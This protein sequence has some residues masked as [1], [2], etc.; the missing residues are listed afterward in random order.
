[1]RHI[2]NAILSKSLDWVRVW[3]EPTFIWRMSVKDALPLR[4]PAEGP[5]RKRRFQLQ[6]RA[7]NEIDFWRGLALITIF[8]DHIPGIVFENYTYRNVAISDA[9]EI[10]VFL[11]GWSLRIV[12]DKAKARQQ[13]A[14]RMILR[15]ESRAF[16]IYIAQIFVTAMALALTAAGALYFSDALVLQWNNASAIFEIPVEAMIGVAVMSHQ[17]GYFDIL[18]LYVA[19]MAA[20]PLIVLVDKVSP[21][22]LLASSLGVY[23]AAL[24]FG[25]NI[26]TWPV[27]D[28][29]FFNPLAWQLVFVC[30]YLVGAPAGLAGFARRHRLA[31]RLAALPGVALGAWLAWIRWF[32]D[33]LAVPEPRLFFMFD[34]T[35]TSPARIV[36]LLCA[37]AFAAGI[38][39]FVERC[40]W[41]LTRFASM[42]GRNSLNVFCAASLLSLGGQFVRYGTSGDFI[43]DAGVL[44]FGVVGMGGMAWMSEWR[45]HVD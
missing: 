19:L 42:L 44:A 13:S 41:P 21:W 31:T 27:E 9:A 23:C 10:F 1:M 4:H 36:H 22:F 5:A 28:R 12:E 35:Y 32:P 7:P 45:E 26:P 20:A 39:T 17:M 30:G 37:V 2:S 18:P 8:I 15:L 33:P 14:A 43:W 38:F 34:K 6:M 3:L 11:A 24:T 40:L 29:W 16:T 25:I